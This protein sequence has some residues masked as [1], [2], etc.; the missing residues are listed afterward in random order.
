MGPDEVNSPSQR[1]IENKQLQNT[2]PAAKAW[3]LTVILAPL[4]GVSGNS[5]GD[6]S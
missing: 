5:M 2:E 6:I 3:G 1:H 4:V